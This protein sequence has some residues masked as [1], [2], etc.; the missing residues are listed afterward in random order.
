MN[1]TFVTPILVCCCLLTGPALAQERATLILKSGERVTG[2][3]VDLSAVGFTMRV[4]NADRRVA[5]NEVAVVEFVAG[6]PSR[7][8]LTKLASGQP[9]IVLRSGQIEEGRLT[10]IG[11]T[12]PL[13]LTVGGPGGQRDLRSSDVAR[14]YYTLPPGV[15]K[16]EQAAQPPAADTAGRIQVA[17][18]QAWTSTGIAVLRGERVAF[19]GSGDIMLTPEASAG[20]GGSPLDTRAPRPMPNAPLG[21]LIGRIG[22]G[23]PFLIGA[24]TEP[25]LMSASGLLSLGINDGQY[26]DNTGSFTVQVTKRMTR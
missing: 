21:A 11:G 16:P 5:E 9:M 10:D 7:D 6:D 8:L 14:I 3:L 24:S 17:A 12:R 15:A 1:R 4:G 18:N 2:D 22:S 23:S 13:R 20:V 19:A 25:I 26:Q